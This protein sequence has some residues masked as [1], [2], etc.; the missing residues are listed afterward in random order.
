MDKQEVKRSS[1]T[2]LWLSARRKKKGPARHKK[3]NINPNSTLGT[4]EHASE[5]S[6]SDNNTDPPPQFQNFSRN[7]S[8]STPSSTPSL[9]IELDHDSNEEVVRK[10]T[11]RRIFNV[12]YLFEQMKAVDHS[13][14][15]CSFKD[16]DFVKESRIGFQSTFFSKCKMCGKK[17]HLIMKTRV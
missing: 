12:Q 5:Q 9:Q 8:P 11:G 2:R 13:P 17:K 1:K 4:G 10:M 6:D 15:N 7:L 14:F 16:M 3:E